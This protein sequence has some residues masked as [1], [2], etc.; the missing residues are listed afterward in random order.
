M[1]TPDNHN[2]ESDLGWQSLRA[3]TKQT[4]KTPLFL[5]QFGEP[6][7][8]AVEQASRSF[9]IVSANFHEKRSR[10]V[11]LRRAIQ[12]GEIPVCVDRSTSN[13][14]DNR[15]SLAEITQLISNILS[16]QKGGTRKRLPRTIRNP[17]SRFRF[18][19]GVA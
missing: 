14:D 11:V 2:L 4:E 16:K 10:K 15:L 5:S 6:P 13:T 1:H 17:S 12:E 8:S 19:G 18:A 9:E 7:C 3:F